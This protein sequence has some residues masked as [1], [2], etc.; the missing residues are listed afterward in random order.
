MFTID[1]DVTAIIGT[2]TP[3]F[4]LEFVFEVLLVN[5]SVTNKFSDVFLAFT[6]LPLL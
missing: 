6:T 1:I 4:K 3:S 5:P 2:C